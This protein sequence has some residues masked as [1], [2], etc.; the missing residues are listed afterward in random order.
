MVVRNARQQRYSG[1]CE[2]RGV[3]RAENWVDCVHDAVV[4][5]DVMRAPVLVGNVG[6]DVQAAILDTI[7]GVAPRVAEKIH[8][9]ADNADFHPI[10]V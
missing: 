9:D 1:G 3:S 5:Q 4:Q 2:G 10:R 7:G 6:G 8:N